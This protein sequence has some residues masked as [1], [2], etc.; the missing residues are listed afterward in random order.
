[1]TRALAVLA[2]VA[3]A[4]GC[5]GYNKSAKRWAYAGNTV[6]ILGGG[7]AIASDLLVKEDEAPVMAGMQEPYKQPIS[8]GIVAG[9]LLVA[10]GLFGMLINATRPN[11]KLSR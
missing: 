4:S 5:F 8:A 2:L 9:A 3:C 1:M 10:S 11:V 6:L 7:A